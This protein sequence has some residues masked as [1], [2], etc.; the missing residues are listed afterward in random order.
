MVAME[1]WMLMGVL[2]V[3]GLAQELEIEHVNVLDF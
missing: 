2:R 3:L 1:V